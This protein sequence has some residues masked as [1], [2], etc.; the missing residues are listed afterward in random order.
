MNSQFPV[1]VL[2]GDLPLVVNRQADA[3]EGSQIV[4]V[5]HLPVA[6]EE[7][8]LGR[9][10][11]VGDPR[12]AHDLTRVVEPVGGAEKMPTDVTQVGH[13]VQVERDGTAGWAAGRHHKAEHT[14]MQD[15]PFLHSMDV[16]LMV[17]EKEHE[18]KAVAIEVQVE[19][20]MRTVPM[21]AKILL[22]FSQSVREAR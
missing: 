19:S 7:G 13:L 14:R 9:I 1:V 10:R 4:N 16:I 2:T 11:V 15:A 17:A 20:S 12:L 21:Q 22:T 3:V 8:M 5:L 18:D 6:V